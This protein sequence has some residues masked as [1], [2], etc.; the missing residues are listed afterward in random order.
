MK[1]NQSS[2]TAEGV[3]IIRA[4]ESAKPADIR[5]CYDPFARMMVP[6]LSYYLSKWVIKSGLYGKYAQG[7]IE[8]LVVRERYIDDFI[9]KTLQGKTGQVVILGAGFDTRA[10]RMPEM[11]GKRVF[12][13]D[14]P[15]TQKVKLKRLARLTNIVRKPVTYVP[16]DFNSQSLADALFKKGYDPETE[17]LFIWQGVTVYL[18]EESVD[19]TLAFI[20]RNAASGS[21]VVFDYFDKKALQDT[22]RPEIKMMHRSAK[23]TQENFLFGIDSKHIENFM[24]ERGFIK[25]VD[26]SA[27]AL[28]RIYFTGKNSGRIVLNGFHIVSAKVKGS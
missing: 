26:S 28:S 13:V 22:S 23:L 24:D 15:D 14:H 16:I 4:I 10:Y 19:Q 3:A 9:K 20:S 7:L 25:I 6:T 8:L 5:I 2:K 11:A 21:A 27:E 1:K 12:D 18:N 17:T